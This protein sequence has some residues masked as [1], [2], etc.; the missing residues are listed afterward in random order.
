[1]KKTFQNLEEKL[2][3]F[4]ETPFRTYT[5]LAIVVIPIVVKLSSPFYNESFWENILVEAHGMLFDILILGILFAWFA[6]G[7]EK[8]K[9][10]KRYR[11]EIEDYRGWHADEAKY[12]I[13]GNIKRLNREGVTKINLASTYLQRASLIG[14][15]LNEANLIGANLQDA[16]LNGANL[17]KAKLSGA[18][19]EKAELL[20]TQLDE[21]LLFRTV[22]IETQ[23]QGASFKNANLGLADLTNASLDFVNLSGADLSKTILKGATYNQKTIWPDGFDPKAAGAILIDN[24]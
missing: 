9:N 15:N 11:E 6:Q 22:L 7:G 23:L 5:L 18:N 24:N 20:G 19:L 3:V 21:A 1:M 10:I 14:V 16:I 12:R 17:N 4:F 2:Q 8:Q 13:I